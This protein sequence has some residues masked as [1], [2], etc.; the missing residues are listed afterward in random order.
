LANYL[1]L[2]LPAWAPPVHDEKNQ[3]A[4][5]AELRSPSALGSRLTIH[6]SAQSTARHLEDEHGW[7]GSSKE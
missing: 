4:K 5:V 3:W 7:S 1:K 6:V 2:Q